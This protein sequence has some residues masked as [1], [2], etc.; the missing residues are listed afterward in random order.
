[1]PKNKTDVTLW[2]D[3]LET[4]FANYA[5]V[6]NQTEISLEDVAK[7]FANKFGSWTALTSPNTNEL[8]TCPSNA[9]WR[10]HLDTAEKLLP[11]VVK[12]QINISDEE[13]LLLKI[14]DP[15]KARGL[16]DI[17]RDARKQ[18]HS[19]LGTIAKKM[20]TL[21][22]E[23]SGA[24]SGTR[25]PDELIADQNAKITT[26]FKKLVEMEHGEL[27]LPAQAAFREYLKVFNKSLK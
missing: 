4:K 7:A 13:I 22:K 26:W 17:R 9:Q 10:L 11:Q 12:D 25:G 8:S 20:K 15:I 21:E 14:E 23:S 19:K 2:G 16:A 1:M 18:P 27:A 5:D 24:S 6:S 3:T